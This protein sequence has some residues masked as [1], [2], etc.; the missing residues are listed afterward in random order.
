MPE[1]AWPQRAKP[2]HPTPSPID[3]GRSRQCEIAQSHPIIRRKCNAYPSPTM[4]R[5][6]L[7]SRPANF[8]FD[9]ST[10][11]VHSSGNQGPIA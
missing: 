11:V 9:I 5:S 1:T 2:N 6:I 8:Y 4:G 3:M 7:I 10:R